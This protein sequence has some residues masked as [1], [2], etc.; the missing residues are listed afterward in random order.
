MMRASG[1]LVE[2]H[3]N[4]SVIYKNKPFPVEGKNAK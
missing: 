2:L 3:K 1:G 4:I